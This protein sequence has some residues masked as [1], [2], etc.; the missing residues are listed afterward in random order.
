MTFIGQSA[1]DVRKLQMLD[2]AFGMDPSQ[3]VGVAFNM[4]N[5]RE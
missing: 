3:L 2:G 4:F 5:N 1:P